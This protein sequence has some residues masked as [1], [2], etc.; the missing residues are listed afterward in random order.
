MTPL[1]RAVLPAGLLLAVGLLLTTPVAPAQQP[2]RPGGGNAAAPAGKIEYNRDIRPILAENCFACHG[3]D[4][5]ARKANLR[6]DKRDM[7]VEAGIIKPGKPDE[8]EL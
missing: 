6:L 2:P 7:A 5:A 1:S 3:P 8:S 4:S